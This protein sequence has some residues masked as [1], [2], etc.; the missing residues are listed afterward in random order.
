M[1]GLAL[2]S[3][4]FTTDESNPNRVIRIELELVDF[5]LNMTLQSGDTHLV[6]EPDQVQSILNR[7]N[8]FNA[9]IMDETTSSGID[10]SIV[11]NKGGAIFE[12]KLDPLNSIN[13][14]HI[15]A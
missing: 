8:A 14:F 9:K 1:P 7:G 13:T 10:S 2:P 11:K 6:T 12:I 3:C 15:P 4:E 5:A